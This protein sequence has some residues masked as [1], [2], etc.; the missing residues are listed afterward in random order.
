MPRSHSIWVSLVVAA[1]YQNSSSV[2]P[3]GDVT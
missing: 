3:D 1:L 2:V